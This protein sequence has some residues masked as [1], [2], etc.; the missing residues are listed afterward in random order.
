MN[1]KSKLPRKAA[2]LQAIGFKKSISLIPAIFLVGFLLLISKFVTVNIH[3]IYNSRIGHFAQ[4]TEISVKR[5]QDKREKF[6]KKIIN[7]YC[8]ESLESSNTSLE[9]LWKRSLPCLTGSFGW[10]VLDIARRIEKQNFFIE[11]ELVDQAGF[12]SRGSPTIKFNKSESAEGIEFLRGIGVINDSKFVCLNVRDDSFLAQAKPIGWHKNRDWSYH[13]YRD[14]NIKTYVVAAEKLANL[15]YTVFRMG[16]LVAEPLVSSH[17]RVI[18]YATNGMRTEFLDIFLGAQCTFS[19]STGAGWDGVPTIFNR[20]IGY[21][22]ILPIFAPSVLTLNKI[23]HPKILLDGQTRGTLN[24]KNLID[25]EIA[26]LYDSQAYMNAG[27][28]IR[29]LSSEELVEAVTEMAQ[30]VEGTFVETPEQKEM[31]AKLKHILGTHPKLQPSPNYYPIRAQFA[32]CFL[33]RYPNFLD[34]LD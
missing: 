33:S 11:S 26:Q 17:P 29:D 2:A 25:R 32:S 12:L 14:S 13:N 6:G 24:L 30:R 5:A 18:D 22:N 28:E 8:F 20:P 7:F 21:V 27:L 1:L 15:G 19:I 23:I 9:T 16:A 31:Q 3:R 10:A 34:G 4:N